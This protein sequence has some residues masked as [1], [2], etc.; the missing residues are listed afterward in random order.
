MSE[1]I[2]VENLTIRQLKTLGRNNEVK[3]FSKLKSADL[4]A[5]IRLKVSDEKELQK[6]VDAMLAP[7]A[8]Q[9]AKANAKANGKVKADPLAGKSKTERDKIRLDALMDIA[10]AS[11]KRMRVEDELRSRRREL[12]QEV[13]E[14]KASHKGAMEREVDYEDPESVRSKLEAVTDAWQNWQDSIEHR[15]LELDPMKEN[16]SKARKRERKAF[17]NSNQLKIRF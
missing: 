4:I 13:S 8:E 9:H 16:L 12:N 6:Q 11:G 15:R 3:G 2:T 1:Q 10:K 5:A 14:S 7:E 17:E